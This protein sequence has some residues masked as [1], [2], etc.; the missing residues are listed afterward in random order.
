MRIGIDVSQTGK[1]KAGCGYVAYSLV[2]ALARLD[3]PNQYILYPTFGDVYLDPEWSKTTVHIHRPNFESG[4]GQ[5]NLDAAQPFWR[6]P[7]DDFESQLKNPDVVIS[8]NFYCPT[9]FKKACLVFLVHDLSYMSNPEW[10][11]E[12]NRTACFTGVFNASIYADFILTP[13][14]YT[15][16]QFQRAYPHYPAERT[17]T[18]PLASRFEGLPAPE[19]PTPLAHLTPDHFW[20]NVGTLEPRKNQERL[21]QAYAKFRLN[22]PDADPLVIAGGK[23]WLLDHFDDLVKDL[24]LSSQVIQLG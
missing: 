4:P 2:N 10:T 11:T 23:G 20:L 1:N 15:L 12:T 17:L 19:R 22:H 5:R 3:T 14:A 13:S 18:I 9:G 6:N 21:L 8:N 24:G 16:Q 7:P